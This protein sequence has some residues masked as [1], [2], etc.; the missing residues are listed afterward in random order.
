MFSPVFSFFCG[1][2]QVDEACHFVFGLLLGKPF[3]PLRCQMILQIGFDGE[4]GLPADDSA[5]A[6]YVAALPAAI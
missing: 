6:R 5:E 3:P 2:D 1:F 4:K